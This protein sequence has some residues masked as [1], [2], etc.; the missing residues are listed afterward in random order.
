MAREVVDQELELGLVPVQDLGVQVQALHLVHRHHPVHLVRLVQVLK[1][2]H[3]QVL[4]LGLEPGL[5]QVQKP[6]HLPVPMLAL[7]LGQD[8]AVGEATATN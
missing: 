7:E 3:P 5:V 6:V 4:T 8:E 2:V 1:L